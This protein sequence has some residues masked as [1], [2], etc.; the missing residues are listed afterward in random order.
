MSELLKRSQAE[1]GKRNRRVGN[2][3]E[4]DVAK[5][6]ARAFGWDWKNAFDRAGAGH[7]QSHDALTLSKFQDQWPFWWECKNRQS[8]NFDQF[9]KRP[10]TAHAYQWFKEAEENTPIDNL[11]GGLAFTKPYAPIYWMVKNEVYGDR[12]FLTR[13]LA[14]PQRGSAVLDF[15]V[16]LD[17]K[18]EDLEKDLWPFNHNRYEVWL[19][20]EFLNY[21]IG[22]QETTGL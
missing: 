5:L 8:W 19:L 1:I 18:P 16:P 21:W 4:R 9:F 7:E 3:F 11:Y 22:C 17:S 10:E 15:Y 2:K 6:I 14:L 13:D 20:E 12:R